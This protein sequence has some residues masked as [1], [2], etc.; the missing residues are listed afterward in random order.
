MIIQLVALP[1]TINTMSFRA[2]HQPFQK[3]SNA[4]TNFARGVSIHG[5]SS[6]KTTFRPSL[7]ALRNRLSKLKAWIQFLGISQGPIPWSIKDA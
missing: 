5:S 4:L 2:E 7:L 3:F 1:Q 6:M